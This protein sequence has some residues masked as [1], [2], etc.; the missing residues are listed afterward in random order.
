MTMKRKYLISISLFT[1]SALLFYCFVGRKAALG[2]LVGLVLQLCSDFFT[3]K[4]N[5]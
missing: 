3:S 4:S 1:T 5:V 2:I